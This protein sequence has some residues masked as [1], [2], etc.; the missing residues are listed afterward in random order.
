M[1]HFLDGLTSIILHVKHGT[2]PQQ[3]GSTGKHRSV[4]C[5]NQCCACAPPNLTLPYI[6]MPQQ[7][8]NFV[9]TY[10][11]STLGHT[12]RWL[13]RL[14]VQL[15]PGHHVR[16]QTY[17][18]QTVSGLNNYGRHLFLNSPKHLEMFH[19]LEKFWITKTVHNIPHISYTWK[20]LQYYVS[21]KNINNINPLPHG[22]KTPPTPR[23]QVTIDQAKRQL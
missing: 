21:I 11:L 15:N 5:M 1:L 6:W 10:C 14:V 16:V 4:L 3:H 23:Q 2:Q 22:R 8:G 9:W 20:N 12:E 18:G 19:E 13:I 7:H 17:A